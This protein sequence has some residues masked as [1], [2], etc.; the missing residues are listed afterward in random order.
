MLVAD[1][2][3]V[4]TL[5]VDPAWHRHKLGTRLLHT[6]ATAAIDR[7]A[8]NLTLEVRASNDA[9]QELYRAF[10]F[11]PAGIRKGYYAETKEDAIM[12]WAN[13]VDSPDVRRAPRGPGRRP[14]P[15]PPSTRRSTDERPRAGTDPRHRDVVRR[16]GRRHRRGGHVGAVVGRQQPGRPPRPLRRRRARDRQ[17]GP[18]RPHRARRRAGV[19]RG[20]ALGPAGRRRG[21]R[22]RRRRRHLRTRAG[23]RAAR[24]RVRRQGAGAGLGRAVHRRQ[25]PRGAPL[26]HP[27]RGARPRAARSWCCSC[28]AATRSSCS[29][30]ATGSTGCSAP[31]STTPPARPSTRS[32]ATSASATPAARP[33]TGWPSRAT[34]RRSGSPARWPATAPTTSPSAG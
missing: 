23:R 18:R 8:K 27:P 26:R 34:P 3:H 31:R 22:G 30:R 17:P 5:A 21:L 6:L 13:D 10:G 12:M 29:W 19:R 24:R 16:D 11:A 4:T 14:C 33:S 7:G 1:D 9:A 2:G 32:P 15:A 20:R 25:P 28:R